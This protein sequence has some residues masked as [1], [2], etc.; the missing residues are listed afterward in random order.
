MFD[1]FAKHYFGAMLFSEMDNATPQGG[2]PLDKNYNTGD[3]DSEC[4]CRMFTDCLVFWEQ[5]HGLLTVADNPGRAGSDFWLTQNGHGAG[6][7]DG[8]WHE[9]VEDVLTDLSK[10][11]PKRELYVGDD[12]KIYF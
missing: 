2:D 12:G 3:I 1:T 10:E 8:D 9:C 11:F 6:F 4:F 7:W 5:I